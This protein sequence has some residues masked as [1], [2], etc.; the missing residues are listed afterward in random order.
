MHIKIETFGFVC[1]FFVFRPSFEIM[2]KKLKP[3]IAKI[4]L[5]KF[6]FVH[7]YYSVFLWNYFFYMTRVLVLARVDLLFF[8]VAGLGVCFVFVLIH[9]T[10]G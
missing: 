10:Q 7:C 4:N 8:T 3:N 2:E 6:L 1:W 5:T 9:N